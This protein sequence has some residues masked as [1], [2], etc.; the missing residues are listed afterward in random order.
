MTIDSHSWL[1]LDAN[2]RLGNRVQALVLLDLVC[3]DFPE[4][5]FEWYRLA[6]LAS[7]LLSE[8]S[9]IYPGDA[10]RRHLTD[11]GLTEKWFETLIRG[12]GVGKAQDGLRPGKAWIPLFHGESG[13]GCIALL[14]IEEGVNRYIAPETV[15]AI[16]C[17]HRSVNRFLSKSEDAAV[18]I[19][20]DRWTVRITD[21]RGLPVHRSHLAGSS[22][23]LPL[24]LAMV[25]WVTRDPISP[26][27]V[28]TGG[29]SNDGKIFPVG[30]VR[31]KWSAARHEVPGLRAFIVPEGLD[32]L[33]SGESRIFRCADLADA[34]SLA[35]G[36]E[37]RPFLRCG[38]DVQHLVDSARALYRNGKYG[39]VDDLVSGVWLPRKTV[40]DYPA[41]QWELAGM[42][43]ASLAHL[44]KT[45]EA[46]A[47]FTAA[48][49]SGEPLFRAGRIQKD[50]WFAFLNRHASTMTADFRLV[51]AGAVLREVLR[52]S[53]RT[54]YRVAEGKLHGTLGQLLMYTGK[55]REAERH[56][57]AALDAAEKA[58]RP[59]NL[60][61][62]GH[63][64]AKRGN[65]N[66]AR[67][68]FLKAER[69]NRVE[70]DPSQ[71]IQN[72]LFIHSGMASTLA[73][74]GKWPEAEKEA[75]E[76][77][78]VSRERQER[79]GQETYHPE[80]LLQRIL[81]LS[82]LH[83]GRSEEARLLL[84]FT[85]DLGGRSGSFIIRLLSTVAA[86]DAAEYQINNPG[87]LSGLKPGALTS[88]FLAAVVD[89]LCARRWFSEEIR[90]LRRFV[91]S[92][93]RNRR[94]GVLAIASVRNRMPYL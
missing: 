44:G 3:R 64:E 86:L 91:R 4:E 89:N 39:M 31:E 19:P 29:L 78:A 18:L 55:H 5:S 76:G 36:P 24:A 42:K 73:Y 68:L 65:L 49:K 41:Q 70:K 27:V 15:E 30:H 14:T 53:G 58:E 43:A 80:V 72:L 50:Q 40:S 92:P 10:L 12:K 8:L 90:A 61:Y 32:G 82:A 71:T 75:Q 66:D 51:E 46:L 81:F 85:I 83:G 57:R 13:Q 33:D 11:I 94:Q 17:A 79:Y 88:S 35:F 77:L 38:I 45:V 37:F 47:T 34:V 9:S 87:A 60:C 93:E 59:R 23:A 26:G 2:L 21:L 16:R 6:R 1:L 84:N 74:E 63:L 48:R 67:R 52:R 54:G 62:L 56:L 28:A 20:E 25:S 7:D 22:L 69:A